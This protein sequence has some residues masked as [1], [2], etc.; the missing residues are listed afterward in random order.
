MDVAGP[1]GPV[2]AGAVVVSGP[3]PDSG[4][5]FSP[6]PAPAAARASAAETMPIRAFRLMRSRKLAPMRVQAFPHLR[7]GYG[8]SVDDERRLGF[9]RLGA[10]LEDPLNLGVALAF[11]WMICAWLIGV[12]FAMSFF[13]VLLLIVVGAAVIFFLREQI[14]G[15]S[16]RMRRDRERLEQDRSGAAPSKT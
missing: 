4:S 6:Q 8:T 13:Q 9:H 16:L 3:V 7:P 5:S 10:R 11:L 2:G 12:A 14:A 15:L 1:V